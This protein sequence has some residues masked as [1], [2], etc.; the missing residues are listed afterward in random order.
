MKFLFHFNSLFIWA[1]AYLSGVHLNTN[2]ELWVRSH[3]CA[4]T[5]IYAH[6][7]SLSLRIQLHWP[8]QF[9]PTSCEALQLTNFHQ[10]S[11]SF[12][13]ILSMRQYCILYTTPWYAVLLLLLINSLGT[14][15]FSFLPGVWVVNGKA[16]FQSSLHTSVW[17][18]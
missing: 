16:F 7:F 18:L 8:L 12:P 5:V 6:S 1:P 3:L 15:C 10:K 17:G 4:Q 14:S 13:L 9:L 2:W 11:L